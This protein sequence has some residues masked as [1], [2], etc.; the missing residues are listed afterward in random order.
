MKNVEDIYPLSPMQQGMLFHTLYAPKAGIYFEQFTCTLRGSLDVENFQRAWQQLAVRHSVLRTHFLWQGLDEPLQIVRQEISLP[1]QVLDWRSHSASEQALQLEALLQSD[2]SQGFVLQQA[3]LMRFFLIQLHDQ[4]FQFVWSFHHLLFDG[5][6]L[7]RLLNDVTVIYLAH[8]QQQTLALPHPRPYRDY[9]AWLQ[10]QDHSQAEAFWKQALADFVAPT[11]MGAKSRHRQG[12]TPTFAEAQ[13]V[14][15]AE[16]T[17]ALTSLVQQQHLTLSTLLQGVWAWLLSTYSGEK[18]VLFGVTVNGRPHALIGVESMIGL[19]I[20]TLP[21]RVRVDEQ[22]ALIPWLQQLHANQ[23]ERE[24]YAYSP[25]VDIHRWSDVP[26]TLPLFESILVFEN[27]PLASALAEENSPQPE[28][29]EIGDVRCLERD[30]LP[31]SLVVAPGESLSI[32]L[33][34]DTERFETDEI[35]RL[36]GQLQTLL[37]GI[38]DDPYRSLADISLLTPPEYD[39]LM[40]WSRAASPQLSD[41]TL[42]EHF[43]AQVAQ[44]P[45]AIALEFASQQLTYREL[46]RRSNQLAHWLQQTHSVGCE[47]RV[48]LCLERSPEMVIAVLAILK[49]GGAYVPLDPNYPTERLR[50]LVEDADVALVLTHSSV[51]SQLLESFSF[52]CLEAEAAAIACAPKTEPTNALMPEHLAYLMYTSGSTGRPKGVSVAHRAIV[53]LVTTPNYV[54]LNARD[55]VLQAAP[56]AFDA[57]TF[58]IWGSLLNGARLVMMPPGLPA[59]T[60]LA[61]ILQTQQITILWLTAGLFHL[62]V[63]QQLTALSPLRY[64]LAG[65]D[66]LS[67]THLQQA[68]QQLSGTKI[69]NGYGPTEN[70]TFSC[71]YELTDPINP[72]APV[73]IGTPINQTQAYVLNAQLQPVPIGVPGELYVGGH[74]LARGY[75]RQPAL[76]ATAFVPHPFSPCPGA[77]LYRTGDLVR[78]R[79]DGC[80]EFL[81]RIDQ[82]VKIR[83]FR[84]EPSE[85]KAALIRHPQ[86]Q[87]AFV[88]PF[89]ASPGHQ[90]LAA[91]GVAVDTAPAIADVQTFLKATLPDYMIPTVVIFLEQLPL[92][93]NGKV[94][95][96]QLP[97]LEPMSCSDETAFVAPSTNIEQTLC[98]LW[99]TVL[100]IERVGIHNN[101]F[102]LGGHSLLAIQLHGRLQEQFGAA[103]SIVDLF[104]YPTVHTLAQYLSGQTSHSALPPNR[105][106]ETLRSR[107]QLAVQQQRQQRRHHRAASD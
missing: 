87:N 97:R 70:T 55:I 73:P 84:I 85:I 38:A 79:S 64:L 74:G 41:R 93:P 63:E 49:A 5:W 29:L 80:L 44:T 83:G 9:I 14:L 37:E 94:D 12:G 88:Q 23:I 106:K 27:Y 95:R 45:D 98:T 24:Q 15:S 40:Q 71:C 28:A 53:R 57:S 46:N 16:I 62:M 30:N 52:V 2:R 1:W 89:E 21:V 78:Y 48:G 33:Q 51:K 68:Q 101:F 103:V 72:S 4:L 3:P 61:S 18:D 11:P 66:V 69:I 102:D 6:C 19:F 86:I 39:Q 25:L 7:A 59:L 36:L 22:D 31:L 90:A 107:R 8:Q 13:V 43:V 99:S 10:Q 76:T 47:V 58:E 54:E 50:V 60:T 81:G 82:Q 77:R 91:Y 104:T 32:R 92:T 17:Q 35:A 42:P 65:G 96:R 67:T 100:G 34:Y 56:L 20:N 105:E 26:G 75:H